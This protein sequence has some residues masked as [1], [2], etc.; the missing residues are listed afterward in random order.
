M[1]STTPAVLGA[2]GQWRRHR[3]GVLLSCRPGFCLSCKPESFPSFTIVHAHPAP[4]CTLP[5]RRLWAEI[6]QDTHRSLHRIAR[7]GAWV[8]PGKQGHPG[9]TEEVPQIS[10]FKISN[11]LME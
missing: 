7:A 5:S 6:S 4:A 9:K 3:P 10:V 2:T 11:V 1:T 8:R